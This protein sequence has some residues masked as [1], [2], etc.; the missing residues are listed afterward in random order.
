M[1]DGLQGLKIERGMDGAKRLG[2][3]EKIAEYRS[4]SEAVADKRC[5]FIQMPVKR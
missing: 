4:L 1:L 3:V 5:R 2:L